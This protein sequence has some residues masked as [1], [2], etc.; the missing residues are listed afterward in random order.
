MSP[1]AGIYYLQRVTGARRVDAVPGPRPAD[2]IRLQ[3]YDLSTGR[4]TTIATPLGNAAH[5][6]SVSRDGRRILFSQIDSA[7]DE[8]MLVDGFR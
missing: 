5:G 6:L 3:Y 1:T 8:L 2:E 4:S 7:I